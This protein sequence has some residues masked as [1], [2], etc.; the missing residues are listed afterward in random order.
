MQDRVLT[1]IIQRER[2]EEYTKTAHAGRI[3]ASLFSLRPEAL[4]YMEELLELAI[5]QTAYDPVAVREQLQRAQFAAR[6]HR[7]ARERDARLMRQ[8]ASYSEDVEDEKTFTQADLR[9]NRV[10]PV[11]RNPW[12]K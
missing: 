6:T 5:F 7:D 3:L 8:V 12:R 2:F 4:R 11:T 1:E 10:V 9:H